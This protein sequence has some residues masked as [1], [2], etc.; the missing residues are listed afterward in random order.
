MN[1]AHVPISANLI[2]CTRESLALGMNHSLVTLTDRRM[3]LV[4]VLHALQNAPYMQEQDVND[5]SALV[6]CWYEAALSRSQCTRDSGVVHCVK[7]VKL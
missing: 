4:Y 2:S 7:Y 5:Y 3:K 6:T 1:S